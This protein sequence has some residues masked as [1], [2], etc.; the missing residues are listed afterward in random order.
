[1]IPCTIKSEGFNATLQSDLAVVNRMD[2]WGQL[3][4][5]S[6]AGHA[7]QVQA[8]CA[9]LADSSMSFSWDVRKTALDQNWNSVPKWETPCQAAAGGFEVRKVKL[10]YDTW[11]LVAVS[12]DPK[13]FLHE[14]DEALWKILRSDKF[15][16]P[17]LKAWTPTIREMLTT[18]GYLKCCEFFG[19]RFDKHGPPSHLLATDATLDKVV[20]EGIQHGRLRIAA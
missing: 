9:G 4:A 13:F 19:Q 12:R 15:T 18:M 11:H 7:Q 2:R 8:I 10:A 14:T 6:L 5:I 3:Y 1:M 20:S 16:T 17:L